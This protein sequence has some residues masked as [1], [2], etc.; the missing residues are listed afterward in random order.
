M[1][2]N[3]YKKYNEDSEGKDYERFLIENKKLFKVI[4]DN[5][6]FVPYNRAINVA[7]T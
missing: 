5:V 4:P 6:T 2:I 3:N 1:D 7:F